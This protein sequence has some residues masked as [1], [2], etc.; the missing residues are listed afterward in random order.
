VGRIENSAGCLLQCEPWIACA[1]DLEGKKPPR[2]IG[3]LY[4]AMVMTGVADL[5]YNTKIDGR[6]F[7]C[8][9]NQWSGSW[10]NEGS[11]WVV[12]KYEG[13]YED[14]AQNLDF[15]GGLGL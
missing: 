1:P 6:L 11:L 15:M 13:G 2:I 12:S 4:D 10:S 8:V 7:H 9:A 5:D 14:T 3:Q